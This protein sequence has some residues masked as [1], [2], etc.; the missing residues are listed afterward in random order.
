MVRGDLADSVIT[1]TARAVHVCCREPA[2]ERNQAGELGD[3]SKVT[4]LTPRSLLRSL[5]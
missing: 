3:L 2:S 4:C 1:A 5:Y